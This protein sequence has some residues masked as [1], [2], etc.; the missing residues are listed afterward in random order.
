MGDMIIE[1][2][3]MEA[4]LVDIGKKTLLKAKD[5]DLEEIEQNETL[6]LSVDGDRWEGDVLNGE[7]CGWG[8]LYDKSNNKAYEGFR[9]GEKSVCFG[10]YYYPDIERIDY[11]G[12]IC[13]GKRCGLGVQYDRS[14]D[15]I[16]DGEW[17]NDTNCTE[18]RI[19]VNS[20]T[21]TQLQLYPYLEEMIIGDNC[22]SELESKAMDFGIIPLLQVIE[23]GD[24]SFLHVTGMKLTGMNHLERVVIGSNCFRYGDSENE[25][26]LKDCPRV[27]KLKMGTNAFSSSCSC[28][29]E[30]T[31]SL[32]CI[33][34]GTAFGKKADGCFRKGSF[35]LKS[36]VVRNG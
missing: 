16:F 24:N 9:I 10:R 27:K 29:I 30:N 18:K 34:I 25:F 19:V 1:K 13:N 20:F 33:E 36:W 22:S 31:P 14:G 12:C 3:P 17:V 15:V 26:C 32:E 4:I 35:V 23:I 2:A 8:V 11:E 7:P 21:T 28:R 5:M 6:D